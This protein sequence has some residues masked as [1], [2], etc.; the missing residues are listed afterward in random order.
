MKEPAIYTEA[1]I[2]AL[3]IKI[4]DLE[5]LVEELYKQSDLVTSILPF[6]GVLNSLDL[7]FNQS[8]DLKELQRCL[9]DLTINASIE[10]GA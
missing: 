1:E 4:E 8:I 3:E 7:P 5:L 2:E 6:M 10:I 9:D